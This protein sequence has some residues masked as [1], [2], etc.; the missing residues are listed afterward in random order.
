MAHFA[1]LDKD[2]KVLRVIVIDN[3]ATHDEDGIEQEILGIAFCQSM[4]GKD[5]KWVQTSYSNAMRNKFAGVGDVFDEKLNAFI[6]PSPFPSWVLDEETL[7]YVPPVA[8]PIDDNRYLWNETTLSWTE[9][10]ND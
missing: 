5:T 3:N 8:L 6:S 1:E 9:V 10:T 4:Y 7:H 2:N